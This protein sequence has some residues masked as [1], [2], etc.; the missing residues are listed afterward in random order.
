MGKTQ[1]RSAQNTGDAQVNVINTLEAHSGAHV[2]HE[3]KLWLILSL[4]VLQTILTSYKYYTKSANK[5]AMKAARSIAG[6]HN[7]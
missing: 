2:G 1:S 5:R 3:L 6:I 4:V 7:I